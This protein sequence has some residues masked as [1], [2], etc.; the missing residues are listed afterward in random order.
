MAVKHHARGTAD[1]P[2]ADSPPSVE[3]EEEAAEL[4]HAQSPDPES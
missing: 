3:A 4:I 2:L 1:Q